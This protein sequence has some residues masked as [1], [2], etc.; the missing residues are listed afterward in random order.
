MKKFVLF[1]IVV[2]L[3]SVPAF[4]TSSASTVIKAVILQ[5]LTIE[6]G[7]NP[8]PTSLSLLG[9]TTTI[10]TLTVNSN[11]ATAWTITISSTGGAGANKGVMKASGVT[12]MYPYTVTLKTAGATVLSG[13][14]GDGTTA[15]PLSKTDVLTGVATV[16]YTLDVTTAAVSTFSPALPAGTYEDTITITISPN[17]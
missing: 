6:P 5:D 8:G 3:V 1:A 13:P 12:E 14:L 7:F 2:L 11:L 17:A 9:G 16:I 10:G 4:A 15:T